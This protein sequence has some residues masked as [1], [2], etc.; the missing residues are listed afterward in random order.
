MAQKT[1]CSTCGAEIL[2]ETAARTGGT[3]VPCRNGTRAQVDAGRHWAAGRDAREA[4]PLRVLW[5]SLVRRVSDSASGFES[6]SEM[7]KL[8]FAVRLLEREVYNGGFEQYFFNSS[9]SFYEHAARGLQVVGAARSAQLLAR[10]KDTLFGDS[11]VPTDT[12]DRRSHLRTL[13]LDS[14]LLDSLDSQFCEDPD[15]LG[16][17]MG[18]FAKEHHLVSPMAGT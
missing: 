2:V 5:M 3:C 4:S 13:R 18:T 7:E 9:G 12:T 17:L 11:R 10:A 6:L 1:S 16:A 15:G 14:N 8:Y